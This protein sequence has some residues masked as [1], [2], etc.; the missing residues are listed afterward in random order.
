MKP[1]IWF[2]GFGLL[3][4]GG[5]VVAAL[6]AFRSK[7][8][9]DWLATLCWLLFGA[10]LLVQGFAPRLSVE[11]N[12]FVIP[13][14]LSSQEHPID[15]AKI[16]SRER[17]MQTMSALLTAAGA[18]GLALLYQQTFFRPRTPPAT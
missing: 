16:V 7:R 12:A 11:H 18:L 13:L 10:G 17:Q 3:V 6:N 2:V 1:D 4:L 14:S 9:R 8:R 5:A 15:P